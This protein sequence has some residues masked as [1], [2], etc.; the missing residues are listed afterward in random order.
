MMLLRISADKRGVFSVRLRSTVVA[1]LLWPAVPV[2]A[3]DPGP[4]NAPVGMAVSVTRVK[5]ACFADTLVV[6]GNVIPRNEI[7]VRPDREGLQIKEVL[8]EAGMTVAASAVLARLNSPSDPNTLVSVTAPAAGLILTAPTVVGQM[9][10]ARGDPLFRIAT[11]A[12]LDLAA[13]V[14]A[15]QS[16]RLAVGQLATI[17]VA[18]MDEAPGYV[19]V[20]SSLVDPTTQLGQT[21]IALTRNPMLRVGAFGRAT[22]S[23]GQSCGTSIP[24][25]A[26]LY[27]PDGAVVQ[28]IRYDRIETRRV[29]AGLTAQGNVQIREG[30]A[31]GDMIVVRAGAF[32]REGDRVRP[33]LADQ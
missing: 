25:S 3:A 11:D 32:L 4:S 14:P 5:S 15:K 16:S 19:R 21:R 29:N 23:F 20:V 26:L 33:V 7:L 24:L 6:M 9:A 27:G 18:G 28:S 2:F 1:L 31:D 22:I 30:L 8:V 17:K 12:E 10:S 13:E